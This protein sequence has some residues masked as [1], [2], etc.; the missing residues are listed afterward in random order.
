M[1]TRIRPSATAAAKIALSSAPV[2][3]S[4]CTVWQSSPLSRKIW[5][6]AGPRFS[7]SLYFMGW[8]HGHRD[9]SFTRRFRSVGNASL[10]VWPGEM[11]VGCE[12]V[13]HRIV[14]RQEVKD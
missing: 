8:A 5:G 12:D 14:V 2:R 4:P 9:E 6:T 13:F 10:N 3:L 7:S 11:R 1:V